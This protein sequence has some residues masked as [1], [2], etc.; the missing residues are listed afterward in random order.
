MKH[1]VLVPGLNNTPAIWE[2]V[3]AALQPRLGPGWQI[4]CPMMQARHTTDEVARD[5]LD[6]LPERFAYAGFSFGGYVGMAML[7]AAAERVD[8][9]A[10]IC[11]SS[12]GEA[13]AARPMRQ[14]AIEIAEAGGYLPLM[15]KNHANTVHPDRVD[16]PDIL[17]R[18]EAM[19]AGYGAERF[20]AHMRACMVRPDRTALLSA[21]RVPR[22][23][24][25]AEQDKVVPAAQMRA[26]ADEIPGL[27]CIRID[28]S[29]HLLPLEQP[30]ALA[31]ALAGWLAPV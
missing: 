26:I 6:A 16:D 29:G 5:L 19:L 25:A 24:I 2:P 28:H 15:A 17:A 7:E 23:L 21:L 30:A 9:F 8:A 14:R 31:N 10:L 22:L 13:E 27:S 1:L 20:I 3:V 11:S 4:H 12:R 18:R